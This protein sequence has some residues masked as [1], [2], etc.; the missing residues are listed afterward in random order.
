MRTGAAVFCETTGRSLWI[1]LH[2]DIFVIRSFLKKYVI[3]YM[4]KVLTKIEICLNIIFKIVFV[5][6]LVKSHW[7]ISFI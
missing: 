5:I 7:F 4:Y 6:I 3:S 2:Q 1:Y